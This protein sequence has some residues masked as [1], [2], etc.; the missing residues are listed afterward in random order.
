MLNRNARGVEGVHPL[1]PQVLEDPG[2]QF[3]QSP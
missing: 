2:E 1:F 3:G